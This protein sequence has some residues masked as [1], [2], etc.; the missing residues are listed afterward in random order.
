MSIKMEKRA[1]GGLS[2]SKNHLFFIFLSLE[3]LGIKTAPAFLIYFPYR[4]FLRGRGRREAQPAVQAGIAELQPNQWRFFFLEWWIEL[5]MINW[6]KPESGS[7][8]FCYKLFCRPILDSTSLSL[9]RYLFNR[10]HLI[11]ILAEYFMNFLCNLLIQKPIKL[12]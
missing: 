7:H 12:N 9:N 6:K 4:R 5:G 2:P 3:I 1:R 11:G 8:V 10:F